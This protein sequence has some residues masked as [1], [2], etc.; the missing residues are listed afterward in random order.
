M[1]FRRSLGIGRLVAAMAGKSTHD[2]LLTRLDRSVQDARE[3][4]GRVQDHDNDDSDGAIAGAFQ[5]EL[6]QPMRDWLRRAEA[7]VAKVRTGG[8]TLCGARAQELR[9]LIDAA[10]LAVM[11]NPTGRQAWQNFYRSVLAQKAAIS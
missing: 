4:C 6:A 1:E 7:T 3:L 10:N 8:D 5:T 2:R 11:R 9:T